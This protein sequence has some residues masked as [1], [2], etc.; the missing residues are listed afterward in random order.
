MAL[1][2]EPDLV[3]VLGSG[4]N[5]DVGGKILLQAAVTGAGG[6][7]SVDD[8]SLAAAPGT[9]L[10]SDEPAARSTSDLADPAGAC[11]A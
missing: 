9:L 4:R 10:E 11:T 1:P 7:R 5:D 2:L 3:A 6:A 8:G